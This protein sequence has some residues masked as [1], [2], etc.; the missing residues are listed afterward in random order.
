MASFN[1]IEAARMMQLTK[2]RL[3][4]LS[5]EYEDFKSLFKYPRLFLRKHFNDL[6]NQI[7]QA[8]EQKTI[9]RT[10][11]DLKKRHENLIEITQRVSQFEL[12]CL[13]VQIDN[14][15]EASLTRDTNEKLKIIKTIL[16][17]LSETNLKSKEVVQE[18]SD[19][20]YNESIKLERV[21]FQ[22]KT[23]LFIRRDNSL[24]HLFTKTNPNTTFG[25]LIMVNNAY[26]GKRI[27]DLIINK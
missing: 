26:L 16:N 4:K 20:I 7:E 23:I 18:I 9:S 13:E 2:V 6:K 12:E 24:E 25:K 5:K 15:F 8:Y 3:E 11:A 27:N 10:S 22:N 21:L 19:L 17:D 14:K 1:Y